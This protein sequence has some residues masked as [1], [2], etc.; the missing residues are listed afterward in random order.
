MVITEKDKK[1]II[2]FLSRKVNASVIYLFGS[3]SQGFANPESDL[4]LA[5]ISDEIHSN[6][7]RFFLSQ[8]LASKVNKDV[9]LID[10]RTANEVLAFQ[11]LKTGIV[12]YEKNPFDRAQIELAIMKKYAKLN[13]ERLLIID[14]FIKKEDV[15]G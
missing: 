12:W 15:H 13:E 9:D 2:H 8:E 1:M 5:F 6:K 4:D 10:L 3:Y 14:D 11:I 7:E